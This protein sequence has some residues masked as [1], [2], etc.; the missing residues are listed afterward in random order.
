MHRAETYTIDAINRM[1]ADKLNFKP[2]TEVS[3]FHDQVTHVIKNIGFPQTY[4][5]GDRYSPIRELD[6]EANSKEKLVSNI[7]IAFQH[8]YA[9]VR[10]LDEHELYMMTNFF[11]E[12][13]NMDKRAI[14][15][16]IKNHLTLHQGQMVVY[17]RLNGITPPSFNGY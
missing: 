11:R 5:T 13:V 7:E 15:L 14:L 12:D 9:I 10:Q 4:I 16:L 2:V 3:T 17:L 6:L 8:L 1:P